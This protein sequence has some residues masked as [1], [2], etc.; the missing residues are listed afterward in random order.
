MGRL[1]LRRPCLC[2]R[3]RL[4]LVLDLQ[5]YSAGTPQ[6]HDFSLVLI[7]GDTEIE[8]SIENNTCNTLEQRVY[9]TAIVLLGLNE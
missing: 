8:F 7:I 1:G 6:I 4:R 3:L 2:R 5:L 9:R